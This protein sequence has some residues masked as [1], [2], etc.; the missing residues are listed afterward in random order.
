VPLQ[1]NQW[2][3]IETHLKLNT[4]G[5]ADGVAEI[6]IDGVLT[7]RQT[8][9]NYRDLAH[10]TAG[11]TLFKIYR[12]SAINMYRYEDDYTVSTTRICCGGTPPR[13]TIA[14]TS[15]PT[16]IAGTPYSVTLPVHGGKAPYG[17]SVVSGSLLAGLSLDKTTGVIYGTPT[18]GGIGKFTVKVLDSSAPPR[19]GTQAFSEPISPS[20]S[21]PASRLPAPPASR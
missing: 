6:W 5:V 17:W 21:A 4:P 11:F 13:M 7:F 15:L 8:T 1:D 3:C 10:A 16:A 18:T 9:R 14:T 2:Y 12:Q 20:G 19:E